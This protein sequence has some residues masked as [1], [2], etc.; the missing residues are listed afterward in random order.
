MP[1]PP[2][3]HANEGEEEERDEKFH[4]SHYEKIYNE[5]ESSRHSQ[6][7]QTGSLLR[8]RKRVDASSPAPASSEQMHGL[9]LEDLFGRHE[10]RFSFDPVI[11][12]FPSTRP[13]AP[14]TSPAAQTNKDTDTA[15][16]A[17]GVRVID[18]IGDTPVDKTSLQ[19][20]FYDIFCAT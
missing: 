6:E 17:S 12:L 11:S 20:T 13:A 14:L 10:A 9:P 3:P 5:Q 1:A 19:G 7:E 18:D 2:P 15:L 8:K 16:P 4:V